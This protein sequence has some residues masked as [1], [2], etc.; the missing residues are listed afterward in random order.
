MTVTK[1]VDD[2]EIPIS[3]GSPSHALPKAGS[4]AKTTLEIAFSSQTAIPTIS[5]PN[6]TSST[7]SSAWRGMVGWEGRFL[8]T[9]PGPQCR[10][11]SSHPTIPL[12]KGDGMQK[13]SCVG[14]G[15]KRICPMRGKKKRPNNLHHWFPL[16]PFFFLLF[17]LIQV[18]WRHLQV[19]RSI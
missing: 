7:D 13:L 2:L 9:W 17:L 12:V 6:H 11:L 10:I 8:Q 15:A 16:F 19:E 1:N 14:R 5:L 18:T 4:I 3:C